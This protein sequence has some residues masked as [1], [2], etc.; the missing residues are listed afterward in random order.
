MEGIDPNRKERLLS[1]KERL[2]SII[3]IFSKL[4]DLEKSTL[5][6]VIEK[7]LQLMTDEHLCLLILTGSLY[8][9]KGKADR[10]NYWGKVM[11]LFKRHCSIYKN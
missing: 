6:S 9:D 5:E 7:H 3:N 11:E 1:P 2:R 8:V 10:L 4:P